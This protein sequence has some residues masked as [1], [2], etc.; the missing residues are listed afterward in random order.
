MQPRQLVRVGIG[1]GG[2]VDRIAGVTRV[3]YRQAGWEQFPLVERFEAAF[4]AAVLLDNDANTTALAEATCGAG[5]E[6]RDLFYLHLSS[7][8]GGGLVVDGRL[9]Q[10]ATTSAGEI[11]HAIVHRN[12]PPCS[13]GGRGHVKSYVAIPALLR[14]LGE[15]GTVSDDLTAVFADTTAA[16]QTVQEAAEL[17][18]VV[19]C[20]VVALVDP[21][22]IVVGGI[23]ARTGGEPFL[24]QICQTLASYLPPTF[25]RAIPVVPA[26]FGPDSVAVGGLALAHASLHQ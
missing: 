9:Y 5:S 19:L 15:L 11:G 22:L 8:V 10:G 16:R 14:R 26:S 12:G 17:L 13:C 21:E 1:F 6:V 7:G 20:N 3:S 23:V 2:P 25:A 18:G 24:E 4:D